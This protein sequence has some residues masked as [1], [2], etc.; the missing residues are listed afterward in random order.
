MTTAQYKGGYRMDKVKVVIKAKEL[1]IMDENVFLP[2]ADELPSSSG[3]IH[4]IR[5]DK[6]SY[7]ILF[8]GRRGG[9]KTTAMTFCVVR[10]VALYNMRVV[11][12]YPIEFM[13]RRHR[14]DGKTYLQHV[15]AE[16]L[17]FEKLLLQDDEYRNVL[18]C[19]DEAP[20]IISHMASQS[21]KNR[22]INA[23]VR[24]I[25]KNSNSLF[26]AAQNAT[27][28]D[29]SIRFQVDVRIECKDAAR[30]MGDNSG[31]ENGEMLWLRWFD[32]SGQWT[33]KTT[34]DRYRYGEVPYPLNRE[35][36]PRVMWGDDEHEAVFN[37][38]FQ[39]D[40][41]ESLR[42]V[43]VKMSSIKIGDKA[44][45]SAGSYPVSIKVLQ[46]A[47]QTIE[48]ILDQRPDEP[49]VFQK[50]FY[51]SLG[52]LTEA[53]K[54]NMGKVLTQFNI[55]RGRDS[56]TGKRWLGFGSFDTAGFRAYIESKA[57]GGALT[58]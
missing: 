32:E 38:W 28:L 12:N 42:R 6:D 34:E 4:T 29:K 13:L 17:D 30:T 55:E 58:T 50:F 21:W 53:D 37:S 56:S 14:P 35:L 1:P 16:D 3:R 15:K 11:S 9:G 23:F 18:I 57:Q 25:R 39:L 51:D 46:S 26:L 52:G 24:Q 22:L 19:I 41:L 54:N 7:I 31:L 2:H 43:D 36:F 20:D 49:D 10:A 40:L 27:W 48:A 33:G 44:D 8:E 5:L 47:L 45:N